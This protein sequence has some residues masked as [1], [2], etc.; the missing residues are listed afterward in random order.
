MTL[1]AGATRTGALPVDEAVPT[2]E[3]AT[4]TEVL[5]GL[6][7]SASVNE[8]REEGTRRRDPFRNVRR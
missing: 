2:D 8:A 1:V 5:T 3:D 4:A 7:V 6:T